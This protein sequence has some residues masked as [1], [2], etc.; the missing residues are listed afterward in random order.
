M[1]LSLEND[2]AVSCITP[3][4]CFLFQ[5]LLPDGWRDV[6]FGRIRSWIAEWRASSPDKIVPD[7]WYHSRDGCSEVLAT[8]TGRCYSALVNHTAI[9]VTVEVSYM[10]WKKETLNWSSLHYYS[11]LDNSA[12]IVK[13][14]MWCKLAQLTDF[15]YCSRDSMR[16]EFKVSVSALH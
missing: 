15:Q 14:I 10:F 12:Y 4:S 2:R 8:K 1:V 5:V 9:L 6:R 7:P 3:C 13:I 16:E 11:V